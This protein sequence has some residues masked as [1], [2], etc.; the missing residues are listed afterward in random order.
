MKN[1]DNNSVFDSVTFINW[2]YI[3]NKFYYSNPSIE[4]C[5]IINIIH[6]HSNLTL[7]IAI[8][9]NYSISPLQT[10]FKENKN[11]DI[12]VMCQKGSEIL[13]ECIDCIDVDM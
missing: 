11:I 13:F 5:H 3:K 6:H 7:N 8:L 2:W 12:S 10:I 1:S 4:N 9:P